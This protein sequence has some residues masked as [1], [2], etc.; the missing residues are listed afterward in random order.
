MGLDTQALA[1]AF[2]PGSIPATATAPCSVAGGCAG[3]AWWAYNAPSAKAALAAAKFDLKTVYPLTI[4]DAPVPGLPDPAAAAA[5]V[6]GQLEVN[7]GLLV[8]PAVVPVETF[9]ADLA[10]GRIDGL[11]L[12]GVASQLADGSGFLEPLFG[13][14]VTTT[15]AGRATGVAD[16]LETLAHTAGTAD[17]ADVLATANDAVRATVPISPLVHPG[18]A[19]VYRSDVTGVVVS[20]LGLDPLGSFVPG[21]RHQLVYQ[22]AAEPA[23]TWC[24]N[25][26]SLDAFR[27]CGLTTEGLFGFKPGSLD[28]EPRL[29]AQCAPNADAT[30]WTCRL[31]RGITYKDGMRLDAG[32]VLA[33]FVAQWDARGPL[34]TAGPPGTFASWDALFGAPTSGYVP[35]PSPAVS[36]TTSPTRGT[37]QR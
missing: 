18:S 23:G 10:A 3:S 17:R 19:A 29:A 30:T 9:M 16:A 37:D 26:S 20:P 36:P 28:P 14:S 7:L 32:D 11:Y 31:R 25:Q 34:R 1:A 15:A 21:D 8:E 35:V 22:G 4:P 12:A 5:A 27:L 13:R 2:G 33:S 6:K 24:G